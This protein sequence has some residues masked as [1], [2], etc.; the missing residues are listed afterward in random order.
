VGLIALPASGLVCV[1]AQIAIYTV[2]VHPRYAPT[3]RP[4]WDAVKA[5][6][7]TAVSSELTLME[8]LVGPLR[9]GDATR[10]M[11]REALWQQV[12][13][14]LLPITQDVL[15]EAAR[16]RALRIALKTPD[17][18]HAATALIHGCALFVTNDTGFRPIAGLPLVLLD[19]V[20]AAP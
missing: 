1:D 17:A 16:L 4:L 5:G 10:A 18:I 9:D 7:V 20:L 11:L 6:T 14:R 13:T 19:D 2:D 3:C 8:T 12:N 15:R